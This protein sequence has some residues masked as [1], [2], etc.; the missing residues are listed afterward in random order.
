MPDLD[1]GVHEDA[2]PGL[3][4]VLAEAEILAHRA[5]PSEE[6]RVA[7]VLALGLHWVLLN[8][9]SLALPSFALAELPFML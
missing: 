3:A 1:A 6:V 8:V 4:D 5:M 7:V 2:A 9:L